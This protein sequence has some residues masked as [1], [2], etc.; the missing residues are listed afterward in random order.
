GV[1]LDPASADP[2][3]RKAI[4]TS[5]A[6]VFT[7]PF[8]RLDTWPAS[9]RRFQEAG[10]KVVALTP[11]ASAMPLDDFVE[12]PRDRLIVVLGSEGA[13]LSDAALRACD[14]RVRITISGDVD[15]LNVVVAAGIALH[16]LAG[17]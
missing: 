16:A 11:A 12:R 17:R 14:H 9:W 2:L 7:V 1:L 6:S 3:Y 13:G 5:M 4:R 10:F 8:T 15:S